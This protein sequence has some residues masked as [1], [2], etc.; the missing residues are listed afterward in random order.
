MTQPEPAKPRHP[1]DRADDEPDERP[2]D[3]LDP[4]EYL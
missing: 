4:G 1:H 3:T 2:V